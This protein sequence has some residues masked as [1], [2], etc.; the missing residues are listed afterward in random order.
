MR[1]VLTFIAVALVT[2]LT[3]A[4]V[5]P[6]F[7][8][9][10]A[11]HAEIEARLGEMTGAKVTLTGPISVRLLPTP[12]LALGE[13]FVSA[14]ALDAPKLSFASARL[15][16]A[17]VKLASGEVRFANIRLEKPK[18]ILARDALGNLRLPARPSGPAAMIGFDR[19]TVEDGL[20]RIL[21]PG[22]G[23]V[24]EIAGV[25]LDA[26][27]PALEGPFR[28]SG[29][30]SGP[31]GEPVVFHLASERAESGSAPIRASVDAGQHWPALEF[32]GALENAEGAKGLRVSGS[33]TLMGAVVG[34]DAPT[35]WRAKGRLTADL[36]R[37]SFEKAEFR[38]GPDERALGASG[39]ASLA[40]GSPARMNIA[41]R[42]KQANIDALLRRNGE[43]GVAPIRAFSWFFRALAP[44]FEGS[45]RSITVDA[46]LMGE[47]IILG[48]QTLPDATATLRS[49]PG[50]PLRVRFDLGLPG[51]SRL[52]GD[53]DL[54]TGASP[55]Y[56]GAID[57][58][59]EDIPLLR[60]WATPS[61][62][63]F[64]TKTAAFTAAVASHSASFSGDVEASA[65]GLVSHQL[66]IALDRS[67]LA[68]SLVVSAPIGADRGRLTM[69]LS[70]DSLD[71]DA[72]PNLNASAA[73]VGDLDL[74][75]ALRANSLH[76]ARVGAAEID[77]GSL[78]L[79]LTKSGP[80]V[81]LERLSLAGLGGA[82]V[83]AQGAVGSEG[84]ALTGRLHAD[85]LR[86]FALL[87]ERLSPSNWTRTLADRAAAISPT[88]LAFEAH[89]GPVSTDWP[90]LDSLKAS[91]AAAQ[92]H[93]DLSLVPGPKEGGQALTLAVDSPDAVALLRQF[94]LKG[95][96]AANGRAHLALQASG[97]WGSGFD[98]N[99]TGAL[100]GTDLRWRG[101]L[102][103]TAQGDEARLFGSGK[104]QSAN[105]A[106]L[107][108]A[109]GLAPAGSAPIGPADIG[110]DM[111]LRGD[112][113]AISRLM[114]TV[115]GVKA[116][117]NL[118]YQP[119]ASVDLAAIDNAAVTQAESAV[120]G[121]AANAP[122]QGGP[123]AEVTGELTVDR[124]P[125]SAVIALALGPPQPAK[126]GRLW[127]EEGFAAPPVRPP[128]TEIQLKAGTIDL[129]DRLVA[130]DFTTTL[131]LD[132]GRLD[133]DDIGVKVEGGA[134]AGRVTLRR[135][136]ENATLTGGLS[137][138]SVAIHRPAFSGRVGGRF[139]FASTGS[140][141]AALIEGLAGGGSAQFSGATL[142]R[143][144]PAALDRVVA[145]AQTPESPL[146][147]TNIAYDL[148]NELNR[149]PLPIPDGSTPVTANAGVVKFGPLRITLPRGAASVTARLDLRE[150][151]VDTQLELTSSGSDLKFWTGPPPSAAVE[152]ED[153]LQAQKRRIDVSSLSA[154][155]AT[156]AIARASD[157]IAAMEADVRERA[158]FNRRLKGE[159]FMDQRQREIEEWRVEQERIKALTQRSQVEREAV[160]KAA[161]EKVAAEKAAAER[162]VAAK[163]A[164]E[165]AAAEKAA[166][167]ILG[168]PLESAPGAANPPEVDDE[169]DANM[170][171]A[172]ARTP[173][174]RPKQYGAPADRTEGGLY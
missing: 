23:A 153:A 64:A 4:L 34:G 158:F 140:S 165:K 65:A 147:E 132:K 78:T 155:L 106:P 9:W 33:A 35:P 164:A 55:A 156:Q 37:A 151:G 101:R 163:A 114:A 62:S 75:L 144:D 99:V 118:S 7:V 90:T 85:R 39:S 142:A 54:S 38:L 88:T 168:L 87:I 96:A 129:A 141:L 119:A 10:S 130:Q 112:S 12:Y 58:S 5:G 73:L 84:L 152:V 137:A 83:E 49:E 69:D 3:T 72:L 131:R 159:R 89:G 122:Q 139:E 42:A 21:G 108:G 26:T 19:L 162:A 150:F 157:R 30:F 53:G 138:N 67:V 80:N 18:L 8:D 48:A 126:G 167:E 71:V 97:A 145:K 104:L 92:T 107:L 47:G 61:A 79:K 154:G 123:P 1:Y 160:E 169:H 14:P 68:G 29:E 82:L 136:G 161:S 121:P 28:A 91:G 44:G 27:A 86:D 148:D 173:P 76:I 46:D 15:E 166:A 171:S 93:F 170:R 103:P 127:S 41:L 20:V 100:A 146:D 95:T 135:N 105:V 51:G 70:S 74:S 124:L 45:A 109:L 125:L 17:L 128:T 174:P 56:R 13:G 98:V 60:D 66:R 63:E 22:A 111:T 59:S 40:Y 2:T 25:Q 113:L 43:D 149:A 6:L 134:V 120:N 133:L 117:G 57:F 16:L 24:L 110:G 143:S 50:G 102:L 115:A 32:E 172:K 36:D 31:K 77:S 81:S 11:H 94:G 52:R 116:N